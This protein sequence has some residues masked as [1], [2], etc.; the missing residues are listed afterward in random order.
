MSVCS[1][2]LQFSGLVFTL[3]SGKSAHDSRF[4]CRYEPPKSGD[5]N[6]DVI[7]RHNGKDIV[8]SNAAY[9][10]DLDAMHRKGKLSSRTLDTARI[11]KSYRGVLLGRNN[12]IKAAIIA[13]LTG[14]GLPFDIEPKRMFGKLRGAMSHM[15]DKRTSRDG[16]RKTPGGGRQFSKKKLAL[17]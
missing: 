7:F 1:V 13:V 14:K 5:R 2:Q 6:G 12:K 15:A 11:A 17:T 10:G 16:Q 8:L 4:R 9:I 3:T